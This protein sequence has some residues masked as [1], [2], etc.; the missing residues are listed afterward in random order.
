MWRNRFGIGVQKTNPFS[1][2]SVR[3]LSPYLGVSMET[4]VIVVFHIK[5]NCD[6]RG[7]G[8]RAVTRLCPIMMTAPAAGLGLLPVAL[9]TAMDQTRKSHLLSSSSPVSSPASPSGSSSILCYRRG[10][11][12]RAMCTRY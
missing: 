5:T 11:P 2:S 4:A 8:I 3:G 7:S 9:S 10:S 12:G 1:A 6:W